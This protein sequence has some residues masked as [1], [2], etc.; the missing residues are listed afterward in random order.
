MNEMCR[1]CFDALQWVGEVP[2]CILRVLCLP[3]T[4]VQSTT[5]NLTS[6]LLDNSIGVWVVKRRADHK[7][8][9]P[10]PR[11]CK[12]HCGGCGN[13]ADA[14]DE[15]SVHVFLGRWLNANTRPI[16]TDSR[17]IFGH[18]TTLDCS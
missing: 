8:L 15:T 1:P 2:P 7:V 5:L 10:R 3:P 9:I 18:A 17:M 6:C 4:F 14:L 12:K 16:S 13:K 11:W